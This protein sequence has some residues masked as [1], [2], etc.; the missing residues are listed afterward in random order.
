MSSSYADYA[1]RLRATGLVPD[2]WLGG[3]ERFRQEPLV[4]SQALFQELCEAAEAVTRAVEAGCRALERQP[5]LLDSFLC[6]T[7][8]Q[9]L[10]WEASRPLWHGYARADVFQTADG[11]LAVCEINADTPTGQ[12]EAVA[13]S[14]LALQDLAGQGRSLRDPNQGLAARFQAMIAA[15]MAAG[16]EGEPVPC[17]GIV[18]ATEFTEDLSVV[19]LFQLWLERM[20]LRVVLG[21][22]WNIGRDERGQPTLMGQPCALFLRHY[23]TDW[24]SE[25]LPVWLDGDPYEDA[26]PFSAQLEVLLRAQHER[27]AVVVNPFGAVLA[28]NK[29]LFALLWERMD[30]LPDDIAALVRRYVPETVR[31][32]A[33]HPEQLMAE[34][35]GWVLKSDYGCEGQEVVLGRSCSPEQWAETLKLAI[36]ERW[37]A[38]RYFEARL[39]DQGNSLNFGPYVIAGRSSGLYVRAQSGPTDFGARS[40]PVLVEGS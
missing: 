8:V 12:P 14:A 25:R 15:A 38:Q 3:E 6:L 40:V 34:Q 27:R 30:L 2:P 4:L 9:R 29:R 24:W 21:S 18:Y 17:A 13:S 23:K 32:D 7:P 26:R 19:Q 5:E 39:D 31:L 33:L 37:V 28:Q 36:P 35:A 16:I 1:R 11:G 10:M 20:G 22:P